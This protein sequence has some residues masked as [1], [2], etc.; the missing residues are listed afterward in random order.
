MDIINS[1]QHIWNKLLRCHSTFVHWWRQG[2]QMLLV[3]IIANDTMM[4]SAN[5]PVAGLQKQSIPFLALSIW[6]YS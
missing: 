6:V 3:H 5:L 2:M 4:D 1:Q